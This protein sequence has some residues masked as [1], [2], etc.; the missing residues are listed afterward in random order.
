[1]KRNRIYEM[2]GLIWFVIGVSVT[3]CLF[4]LPIWVL[5]LRVPTDVGLI[6]DAA[7]FGVWTYN[8]LWLGMKDSEA[9]P[10]PPIKQPIVQAPC[11]I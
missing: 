9:N 10:I 4:A 6:F 2:A 7:V 8:L 3:A 1:M 11:P 5:G